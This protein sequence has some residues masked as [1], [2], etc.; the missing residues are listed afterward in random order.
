M[1]A[2]VPSCML[3]WGLATAL[4]G[5]VR[6]RWQLYALRIAI[7]CLEGTESLLHLFNL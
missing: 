2:W 6:T 7:G 1:V 3:L 5:W 4:H